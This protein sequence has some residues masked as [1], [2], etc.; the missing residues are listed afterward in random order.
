MGIG[1][2]GGEGGGGFLFFAARFFAGQLDDELLVAI[3]EGGGG[4]EFGLFLGLLFPGPAGVELVVF[5]HFA[6][7]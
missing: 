6:G 7:G 3:R 1:Q 2:T 5:R 4:V